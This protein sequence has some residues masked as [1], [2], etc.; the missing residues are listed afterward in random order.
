MIKVHGVPRSRTMRAL[1]MLEEL[2]VPYENVKVSFVGETRKP[3]F[4]RLNPNGRIPVLQDGDLVLWESMAINLYLARKYGKGLWP[5]TPE[6]E[7]RAYQ[8]SLW[9]ITELEP[10]VLPALM[11]RLILPENERDEKKVAAAVEGFKQPLAVL[12]AALAGR[13]YLLGG[14]FSVADL[15]VASVMT[16]SQLARLDLSGAKNVPG[17]L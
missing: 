11:H 9:A 14:A 13:E 2:G 1:W 12:D 6:D 17:W 4:L 8:W 10:V 3:E 7:G 5:T 15:N 16:W